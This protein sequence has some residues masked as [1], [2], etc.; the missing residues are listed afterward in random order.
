MREL[1]VWHALVMAM[2]MQP[3]NAVRDH[4]R[5]QDVGAIK[6]HAFGRYMARERWEEIL[7]YMVCVYVCVCV[8]GTKK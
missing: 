4:W 5:R 6:A 7:I 8:C 2:S 1:D 3:L